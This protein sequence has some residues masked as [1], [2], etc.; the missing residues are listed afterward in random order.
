MDFCA[1]LNFVQ[2]YSAPSGKFKAHV[3]TP[4]SKHQI[5]SLVVCLPSVHEGGQLVLRHEGR[6]TIFDWSGE[7]N[8]NTIQWAAF[9][10]DCEHEVLEVTSGHRVTLT[11][12]L[13]NTCWANT[14]WVDPE[15]VELYRSLKCV[16]E[17]PAFFKNGGYPPIS[18]ALTLLTFWQELDLGTIVRTRIPIR[19]IVRSRLC[20]QL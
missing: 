6:E 20:L 11:Y 3:D 16:V 12:N 9:Y 7:K 1:K 5:A 8:R 4:R 10:S 15:Q 19:N 2:V 13:Y 18:P 14:A 17:Q